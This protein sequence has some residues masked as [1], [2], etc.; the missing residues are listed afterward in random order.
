[1][2]RLQLSLNKLLPIERN[3]NIYLEGIQRYVEYPEIYLPID[4]VPYRGYLI[5]GD[6]HHRILSRIIRGESSIL[7]NVI[8]NNN[9]VLMT[10]TGAFNSFRSVKE[11]IES[12]EKIWKPGCR[13]EGIQSF[14]DYLILNAK[15]KIGKRRLVA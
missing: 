4:V 3:R 12:Y 7:G 6:G 2:L 9:D 5:V 8:E 11:F 10:P 1:M 13:K 15:E 14:Y